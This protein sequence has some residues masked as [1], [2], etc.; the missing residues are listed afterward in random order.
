MQKISFLTAYGPQ[1]FALALYYGYGGLTL[2]AETGDYHTEL[3]VPEKSVK[4]C[5]QRLPLDL[6]VSK[7]CYI[8]RNSRRSW[9]TINMSGKWTIRQLDLGLNMRV[10]L[11][12]IT[13]INCAEKNVYCETTE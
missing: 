11:H 8:Q 9:D 2:I 12:N 1:C 10:K 13:D 3:F 5:S 4:I 7:T 6:C